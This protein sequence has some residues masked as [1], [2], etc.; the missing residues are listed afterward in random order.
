GD[1]ATGEDALRRKKET[2]VAGVMIGRAAMSNPWIFTEIRASMG[3]GPEFIA[4][5]MQDKW[6]LINEHCRQE[7]LRRGEER[8]AM[9]SMRAR[10]MAYTR[11]MP[12]GRDLRGKLQFVESLTQLEDIAATHLAML[13]LEV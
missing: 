4:P 2:G 5:T 1:I 10:L 3:D 11:G 7:V 12:G 8:P 9:H 13:S 6:S